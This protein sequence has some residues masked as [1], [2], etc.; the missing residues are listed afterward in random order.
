MVTKTLLTVAEFEKL[1]HKE[2]VRYELDEGELVEMTFPTPRH[3]L[4]AGRLYAFLDSFVRAGKLGTVFPSDTG[5]VLS[6]RPATM[7]G[8]D[9]SFIRRE[10]STAI[11]LD[12]NIES[13]PD[14]A[15][16]VV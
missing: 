16:E 12:H 5:Y 7:R 13:A 8:P 11:D 2:G 6:R 14:L 9:I 10:R 3:N 15:V 1:P 4:I